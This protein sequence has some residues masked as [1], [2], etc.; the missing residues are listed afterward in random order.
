MICYRWPHDLQFIDDPGLVLTRTSLEKYYRDRQAQYRS[1][2][3]W[4]HPI[5]SEVQAR[6][7]RRYNAH[8]KVLTLQPK[9]L[10]L[11]HVPTRAVKLATNHIG[12]AEV[13]DKVENSELLHR[14]RFPDS[15]HSPIVHVRRLTKYFPLLEKQAQ[16]LH[17]NAVIGA[18][19]K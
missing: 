9:D 3:E 12:P 1:I 11:A 5:V 10:V 6:N 18:K 16:L 14:V 17:Q 13:I 19:Q 8:Q 4:M 7:A 2:T 15:N